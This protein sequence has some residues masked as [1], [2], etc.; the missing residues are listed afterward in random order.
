MSN[1]ISILVSFES[2]SGKLETK[3]F[4]GKFFSFAAHFFFQNWLADKHLDESI[5]DRSKFWREKR[6]S[7][8]RKDCLV[9]KIEMRC[10]VLL[11]VTER[12]REVRG[13]LTRS[14]WSCFGV[15][16]EVR[17]IHGW[18]FENYRVSLCRNEREAHILILNKLLGKLSELSSIRLNSIL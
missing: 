7:V 3:V 1:R 17:V 4:V 18:C 14:I 9:F 13:I 11:F 2:S 5:I 10:L 12:E 8:R 16:Y 6:L 15:G